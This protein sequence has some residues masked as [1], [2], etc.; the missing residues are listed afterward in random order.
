MKITF[1]SIFL[2]LSYVLACISLLF[3][4]L[5]IRPNLYTL[6]LISCGIFGL[7]SFAL[8]AVVFELA[9]EMTYPVSEGTSTG[10]LWMSGQIQ[11]IFF[12]FI[13]DAFEDITKVCWL[14]FAFACCAA[15]SS[16]GIKTRYLRLEAEGELKELNEK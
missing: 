1:F 5:S 7:C 15:I 13:A 10:F 3:W 4:A 12:I 2:I 8:I 14:Y 11:A 16:F 9:A 6:V